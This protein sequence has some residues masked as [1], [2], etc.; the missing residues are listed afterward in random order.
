MLVSN[1]E[2]SSTILSAEGSRSL[3]VTSDVFSTSRTSVASRALRGGVARNGTDSAS[4]LDFSGVEATDRLTG[5]KITGPMGPCSAPNGTKLFRPN[6]AEVGDIVLFRRTIEAA[7]M[8]SA[9]ESSSGE[10]S[11]A[12]SKVDTVLSGVADIE[13]GKAETGGNAVGLDIISPQSSSSSSGT[14]VLCF[15][16]ALFVSRVLVSPH[17]LADVVV[18]GGS[19]IVF[20]TLGVSGEITVDPG[21]SPTP[22]ARSIETGWESCVRSFCI[23]VGLDVGSETT[24]L[25]LELSCFQGFLVDVG[26]A[27]LNAAAVFV[28]IGGRLCL[29]GAFMRSVGT[30][31]FVR[32]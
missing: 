8:A 9:D 23:A 22:C 10:F 30:D 25:R 29:I 6:T 13:F 21:L 17:E 18:G 7:C 1:T 19:S 5:F 3:V 15:G 26:E 24:E 16:T 4:G 32:W 20:A 31:V 11:G 12:E 28:A 27:Q 14:L 2:K